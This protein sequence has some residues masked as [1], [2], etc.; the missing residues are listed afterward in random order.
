M[1]VNRRMRLNIPR[2]ASFIFMRCYWLLVVMNLVKVTR[3]ELGIL[4][5]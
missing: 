4:S 5:Y 2:V 3:W 1:P